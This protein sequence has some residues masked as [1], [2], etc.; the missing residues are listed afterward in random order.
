MY[1]IRARQ[2]SR[3]EKLAHPFIE[4]R[5]GM[6]ERWHIVHRGA[7]DHAAVLGFL[8]RYGEPKI[9]EPLAKAYQRV[10]ESDGWKAYQDIIPPRITLI[11]IRNYSRRMVERR[12]SKLARCCVTCS[13]HVCLAVPKRTN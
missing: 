7:A 4:H 11:V 8:L 9:G 2:I 5:V 3:L 12:S 1:Q 6:A 10:T 13:L